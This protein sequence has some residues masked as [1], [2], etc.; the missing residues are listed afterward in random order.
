MTSSASSASH[1][2]QA[3]LF[4]PGI[5]KSGCRVTVYRGVST[6]SIP[7]AAGWRWWLANST[8]A[9]DTADM[10]VFSRALRR[11]DL[12]R[13]AAIILGLA[14]VLILA[15]FVYAAVTVL[16]S[17]SSLVAAAAAAAI[18]GAAFLYAWR[19]PGR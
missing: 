6:T 10:A 17:T 3:T 9:C 18:A 1:L 11:R 14:W 16:P 5:G 13:I 4:G 7:G 2:I 19:E 12:V 8:S 15:A